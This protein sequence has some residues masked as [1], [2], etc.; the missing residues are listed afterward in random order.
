[1]KR[2]IL[3]FALFV[4]F[5]N[6]TSTAQ[7][8]SVNYDIDELSRAAVQVL[9]GDGSGSGTLIVLHNEALVVTNRHVVEN[10]SEANI[11]IL[12]DVTETAQPLFRAELR[13]FSMEYDF[14]YLELTHELNPDDL[15][16]DVS[17]LQPFNIQKLRAGDYGFNLPSVILDPNAELS[18]GAEIAIF[19][20][21]GIGDNELVYTNGSIASLQY[22]ELNGMRLPMWYRTSAEMSPG[23]SGGLA[24]D[25][26]GNFIGIPTSVVQEYETGGRLGNLLALPFA[27]ALMN[28]EEQM[29]T[30]WVTYR[31]ENELA[32]DHTAEPGFG[33]V[34]LTPMQ[35]TAVHTAG[36]TSGGEANANYLGESCVGY[37]AT[38]PDYRFTLTSPMELVKVAF[39][40][41]G[42]Q[43]SDPT[44]IIRAPDG[45]WHCNDD[46]SGFDPAVYFTN[47]AD[48]EY[49]VW[50]GSFS[51]GDFHPGQIVISND[52]QH[53]G[54]I[55]VPATGDLDFSAEPT[56]GTVTLEEGFLPDPHTV[57]V[58]AGGSVDVSS[59]NIGNCYGYAATAPDVRLFWTGG[60]SDLFLSFIADNT[61]DDTTI[62]IND[63]NGNWHCN[64]DLNGLNPGVNIQSAPSGQY[65]IWVATYSSGNYFNGQ[66]NISEN[67]SSTSS[68][69]QLD[70]SADPYFGEES[71]SAGFQPNP[72]SVSITAGGSVDLS[73]QDIGSC[74]GHAAEAPDFRLQWSGSSNLRIAFTASSTGDDTVIVVNDPNGNWHCNDDL[75]GL[76]PGLTFNSA[77]SGQYDVWVGS[78]SEG[79]YIEGNLTIRDMSSNANSKLAMMERNN[80]IAPQLSVLQRYNDLEGIGPTHLQLQ[81]GFLPDPHVVQVP[82]GG[83]VDVSSQNIGSCFGYVMSSPQAYLNWQGNGGA[84]N[85]AYEANSGDAVMVINDGN[86]NWH[87]NDDFNGIDPGISFSSAPSG[88]YQ[89]WVGS[90]YQGQDIQGQLKV[91]E[92]N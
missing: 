72:H 90:L 58:T 69:A 24:V 42:G 66:L 34:S 18:R 20:Y 12:V 26:D 84:L 71:L 59:Q 55:P 70:F 14:A 85:F 52:G 4:T 3:F 15:E 6:P 37:A 87:C 48:G 32:L 10:F 63:P 23:N 7:A 47:A 49:N 54:G 51:E 30:D 1:M 21:P 61:S 75:E 27:L 17:T 9:V 28:D 19:G 65:D 44:M 88:V 16:A 78:Y 83:P 36:I 38:A 62:V 31:E 39:Q 89:I 56:F 2:I 53:N 40:S 57:A 86:G 91:S 67:V 81:P 50:V 76:N 22:G 33:S 68:G 13:G 43:E 46:D 92:I 79:E 77:A 11:G 82:A 64:D 35:V 8:Q 60:S 29:E 45:N 73:T 41:S 74:Y 5:V 80:N 25:T